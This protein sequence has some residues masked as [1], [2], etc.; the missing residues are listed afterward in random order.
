MRFLLLAALLLAP[1]DAFAA[2][3]AFPELKLQLTLASAAEPSAPSGDALDFDLLGA[4]KAPV[5]SEDQVR[6][7]GR[8]RLRRGMLTAHQVGGVGLLGFTLATCVL[9]QLNYSDRFAG[10]STARWQLGHEVASFSTLGLFAATGLMALL[11]PV[12]VAKSSQGLDRGLLHKVGMATATAGMLAQAG[13]GIYTTTRE[14]YL[15]QQDFAL[16]HLVV[17]YVTLAAMLLGVGAMVF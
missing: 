10:P 12:P 2:G 17:G 11:A 16:A 15:N 7:E 8:L 13:L 1:L 9:G 4:A 5:A 3:E 14:G 6:M